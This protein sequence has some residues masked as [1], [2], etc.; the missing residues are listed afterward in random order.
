MS[1]AQASSSTAPSTTAAASSTAASK[2]APA[3]LLPLEEDDEFEEFPAEGESGSE[4]VKNPCFTLQ[5]LAYH[6]VVPHGQVQ[7]RTRQ[8]C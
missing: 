1:A 8:V 2:A 4:E 6:L 5:Q 7:S 3:Q